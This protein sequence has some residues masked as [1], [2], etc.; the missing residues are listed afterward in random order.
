MMIIAWT[1]QPETNNVVFDI[2]IVGSL[3]GDSANARTAIFF[4]NR[5][6]YGKRLLGASAER[7]AYAIDAAVASLRLKYLSPVSMNLPPFVA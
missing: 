3:R 2:K 5:D 1:I 7:T 6:E 4:L